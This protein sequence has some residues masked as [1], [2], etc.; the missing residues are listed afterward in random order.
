MPPAGCRHLS[1]ILMNLSGLFNKYWLSLFYCIF[2]GFI[3]FKSSIANSSGGMGW[4][5]G[6]HLFQW[7]SGTP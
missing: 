1:Y 2:I 6:G 7:R 5:D 4:M 3:F